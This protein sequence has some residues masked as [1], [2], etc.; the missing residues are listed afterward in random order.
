[1]TASTKCYVLVVTLSIHDNIK[2]LENIKKRF[3]RTIF[4]EQI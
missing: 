4:W 2:V 1:M 3:R